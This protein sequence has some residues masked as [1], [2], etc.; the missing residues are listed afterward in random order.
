[1]K[2]KMLVTSLA[3]QQRREV[4]A[5]TRQRD[6]MLNIKCTCKIQ[7]YTILMPSL[8]HLGLVSFVILL[9]HKLK[10]CRGHLFSS[11]VKIM[12]FISDTRYYVPVKLCRTLTPEDVKLKWNLIWDIIE[13]DWKGVGVTLNGKKLMCQNQLW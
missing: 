4:G 1:M 11:A 3:L 13:I 9:S 6:I 8:S 12:L 5:V 7:V 10:L 2:L